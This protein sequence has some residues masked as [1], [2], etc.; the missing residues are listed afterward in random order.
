MVDESFVTPNALS[1]IRGFYLSLSPSERK[2]ADYIL[3]NHQKVM[4][5]TLAELATQSG[6]SDATVVR[7]C[8]ALGFQSYLELKIALMRS[9]LDSPDLIFDHVQKDDAPLTIMRKV[10]WGSI[11]AMQD[12]LDLL[13]EENLDHA[14]TLLQNANSILIVGV[15][16]SSPMA[17]ELHN[18]LSRLGLNCKVETDAYLQLM[19]AALLDEKDV[20]V[21]ISQSGASQPPINTSKEAHRH[22]CKIIVITGNP[23]SELAKLADVVLLSVSH[24]SRPETLASRVAQHALIQGIYVLIAMRMSHIANHNEY[25]IWDAIMRASNFNDA[26]V[27]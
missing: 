17:H 4:Q 15:G 27:Q 16:T 26:E 19:R 24:E 14:V 10:F 1:H 8:R 22:G 7:F 6:V 13:N 18:R 21:A 25:L 3:A 2:V 9:L 11:Q 12:T 20:L 23:S 5:M